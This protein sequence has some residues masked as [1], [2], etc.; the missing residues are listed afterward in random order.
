MHFRLIMLIVLGLFLTACGGDDGGDAGVPTVTPEP[1][2]TTAERIAF[3]PG[4]IENPFRMALTPTDTVRERLTLIVADVLDVR[5]GEITS[6]ADLREDLGASEDLAALAD[7]LSRDFGVSLGEPAAVET[8]DDLLNA[9]YTDLAAQASAVIFEVTRLYVEV[10]VVDVPGE[11]LQALCASGS[12]LVTIPWLNGLSVN[13]AEALNCGQ[14]ALLVAHAAEP[15]DLFT[16]IT[17]SDEQLASVE[18]VTPEATVEVTAEA[19]ADATDAVEVEAEP[20]TTPS[21]TPTEAPTEAPTETPTETPEEEVTPEP[22]APPADVLEGGQALRVGN[23]GLIVVDPSFGT[24]GLGVVSGRTFCRL[25]VSDFYSWLLP[26]IVLEGNGI[27]LGEVSDYPSN[28]ALI[29]AVEAGD[30]AAAGISEDAYD[31][32]AGEPDVG[33]ANTSVA[34]PYGVLLYPV[35]VAPA[36]RQNFNENLPQLAQ[37]ADASRPLRLLLGQAAFVPAEPAR[38]ESINAFLEA[39]NVDL[40]QLAR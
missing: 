4:S 18:E 28:M 34:F 2:L 21:P 17:L 23:P 3:T 29:E 30:C 16:P 7:S 27:T 19:T 1:T 9:V 35:D 10:V 15:D 6:I 25:D 38:L 39:N 22:T 37:D 33:I 13:A 12:G 32:L 24:S 36:E 8:F 40:A 5:V 26:S 14:P 31:A 20:T 11:G